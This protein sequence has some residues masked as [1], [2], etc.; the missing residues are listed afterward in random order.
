MA[1]S[2]HRD[3]IPVPE[4]HRAN[5]RHAVVDAMYL[6]LLLLLLCF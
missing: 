1:P 5:M 2:G 6:L 4:Q 3:H